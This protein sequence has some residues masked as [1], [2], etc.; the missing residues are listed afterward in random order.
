MS[1]RSGI[2]LCYPLEE[3]RLL[4]WNVPQVLIQ[5]KLDGE[6]CRAIIA[7]GHVTLL[8]SEC[9]EINSVPHIMAELEEL[10]KTEPYLELDGELYIHD[11]DFSTIHSIVGRTTNIHEDSHKIEFHVF[12]QVSLGNQLTRIMNM[13]KIELPSIKLVQSYLTHPTVPDIMQYLEIFTKEGY[14]G[15][16]VRNPF[17]I[18]QRKR[19]T[20]MM[21]FKPRKSDIYLIIG[22]EEEISIN[23]EPKGSLGAFV[24]AGEDGTAFK[25]GTGFS[26]S[27][28][29]EY[30]ERR[31][32]L[33]GSYLEV[34]YQSITLK[35]VPRF[36]VFSTLI[37][38]AFTDCYLIDTPHKGE[39]SAVK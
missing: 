12:D 26:A 20:N 24:C 34:K 5:P 28:R 21:K 33:L 32:S 14:E 11:T 15:I 39:P 30:W 18:Y 13:P 35:K 25:V 29:K 9:N 7:D 8:S 27:Q 2:M 23:G 17:G 16:V 22:F 19:T 38:N 10:G 6:R 4:K 37:E 36:P 31:T 3:K 1:K